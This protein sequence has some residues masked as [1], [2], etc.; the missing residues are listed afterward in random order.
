MVVGAGLAVVWLIQ[1]AVEDL[2]RR[3]K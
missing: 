1:M 2:R 3:R